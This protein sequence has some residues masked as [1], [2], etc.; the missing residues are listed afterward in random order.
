[1]LSSSSVP[2]YNRVV[3]FH[4][5][6]LKINVD[7]TSLR[8]PGLAGFGDLLCKGNGKCIIGFTVTIS[9]K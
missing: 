1:M 2:K 6:S 9:C 5:H 7:G 3:T 4:I 8:N